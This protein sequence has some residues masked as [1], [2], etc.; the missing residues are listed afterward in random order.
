MSTENISEIILERKVS[1]LPSEHRLLSPSEHFYVISWYKF[2]YF[3]LLSFPCFEFI[4]N[5]QRNP[6][7]FLFLRNIK[8]SKF[9][10]ITHCKQEKNGDLSF[11]VQDSYLVESDWINIE[12]INVNNRNKWIK[13]VTENIKEKLFDIF[14]E[15]LWRIL[16]LLCPV[17]PDGSYSYVLVFIANHA[18]CDGKS[19]AD[20]LTNK[21]M[22]Y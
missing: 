5:N 2:R 7:A 16:W 9:N 22:L 17:N 12:C 19:V 3:Y 4:Q 21:F 14:N 11:E 1:C 6:S 8:K 10:E 18:I 15:P 13:H 20:L